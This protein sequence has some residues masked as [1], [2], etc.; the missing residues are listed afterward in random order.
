LPV[1]VGLLLTPAGAWIGTVLFFTGMMVITFRQPLG[2][3]EW[4]GAAYI[5]TIAGSAFGSPVTLV[6]LP[7]SYAVL[8]RKQKLTLGRLAAVGAMSG[9]ISVVIVMSCFWGPQQLVLDG[10]AVALLG[11]V[12]ADGA[13]TGAICG[14]LFGRITRGLR[15]EPWG[16]APTTA[17]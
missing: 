1:L 7:A 15:P 9:F 2:G 3:N 5:G 10:G 12:A 14:Y 4:L 16:I 6:V 13:A 17:A 8:R 11:G